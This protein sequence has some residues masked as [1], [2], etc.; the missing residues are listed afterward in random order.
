MHYGNTR[1][2]SHWVPA[3]WLQQQILLESLFHLVNLLAIFQQFY[4]ITAVIKAE[5][6][7]AANSCKI[8]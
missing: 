8:V 1:N 7:A 2:L 3:C 6:L 4:S 5:E